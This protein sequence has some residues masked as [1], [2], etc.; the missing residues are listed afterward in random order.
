M[1]GQLSSCVALLLAGAVLA[2][3]GGAE[4]PSGAGEVFGTVAA[5]AGATE[6]AGDDVAASESTEPAGEPTGDTASAG[7]AGA[8]AAGDLSDAC[9]I[10]SAEQ[11]SAAY[12]S[13]HAVSEATST[14]AACSF[15]N[16]ANALSI[17]S[18]SVSPSGGAD[19]T[20]FL[21]AADFGCQDG[22]RIEVAAGD[23]AYACAL[24][25]IPSAAALV[26]DQTVTIVGITDLPSA[27]GVQA[28]ADLLAQL[29]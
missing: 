15:T 2:A 6:D 17:V 19:A 26:G 14:A 11:V 12:G 24:L 16:T 13:D 25:G 20:S 18:V 28:A 29:G 10:F 5:G 23:A 27:E 3:C 1:T 7:P 4:T 9:S 22:T 21:A 8:A